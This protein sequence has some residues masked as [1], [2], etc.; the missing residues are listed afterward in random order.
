MESQPPT[1]HQSVASL[2]EID[3]IN[4]HRI[5]RPSWYWPFT[6]TSVALWTLSPLAFTHLPA[7]LCFA[8]SPLLLITTIIALRTLQPPAVRRMRFTPALL[9][10]LALMVIGVGVTMGAGFVLS[11]IFDSSIPAFAAAVGSWAITY[12]GGRKFDLGHRTATRARLG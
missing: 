7:A 2:H 8:L 3:S 5:A 10:I 1:A 12:L 11:G 4:E 9:S 6:A